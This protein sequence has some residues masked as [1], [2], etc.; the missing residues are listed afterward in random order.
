[1]TLT[2]TTIAIIAA[3]A[4]IGWAYSIYVSLI[5]KRNKTQEAFSSIDV[6]LK[7]R[8]DLIPNLLT[9]AQKYIDHERS[10]IE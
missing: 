6:Q 7:K 4:V 10:L 1:M 8:Y 2:P 9:I 3:V 5:Q